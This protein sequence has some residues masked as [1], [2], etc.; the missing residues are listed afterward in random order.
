[1]WLQLTLWESEW[2]RLGRKCWR[3]HVLTGRHLEMVECQSRSPFF[4]L[5]SWRPWEVKGLAPASQLVTAEPGQEARS[6]GQLDQ[7]VISPTILGCMYS[8]PNE[9]N[10]S[11]QIYDTVLRSYIW[12]HTH[13]ALLTYSSWHLF[14]V[15]KQL[16]NWVRSSGRIKNTKNLEYWVSTELRGFT[17]GEGDPSWLHPG[18]VVSN[19]ES[20]EIQRGEVFQK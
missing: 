13:S 5:F 3:F 8:F 14:I 17:E 11:C 4:S 15:Y 16:F 18:G 9:C 7:W 1:M 20:C 12:V 6:M 19:E 2:A 10:S